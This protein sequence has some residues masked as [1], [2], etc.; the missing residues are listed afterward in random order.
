MLS[1]N[2]LR[3]V[4]SGIGELILLM[5]FDLSCNVIMSLLDEMGRL[6]NLW[7]FQLFGFKFDLDLV[8]LESKVQEFIGFFYFKFK[9]FVFYYCMKLVVVG[10]VG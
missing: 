6:F 10:K 8:I 4:F 5:F 7:D 9:N 3:Q 2:N 1:D